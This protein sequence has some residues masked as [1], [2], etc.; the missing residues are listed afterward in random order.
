MLLNLL[1][2]YLRCGEESNQESEIKSLFSI[3]GDVKMVSIDMWQMWSIW[4]ELKYQED[5]YEKC[6]EKMKS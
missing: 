1:I 3:E 5:F 2:N 4:P 6:K